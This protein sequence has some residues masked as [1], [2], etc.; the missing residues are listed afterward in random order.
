MPRGTHAP[1]HAGRQRM[2]RRVRRAQAPLN[3]RRR[4]RTMRYGS[5][6]L[7]AAFSLL[8]A[9]VAMRTA[10]NSGDPAASSAPSCSSLPRLAADA[11][12]ATSTPLGVNVSGTSGLTAATAQFGHMPVIRAYYGAVVPNP[13][14]WSTGVL[15]LSHASVV[16]SFRPP[17]AEI[18]SGADDTAL[19]RFF[20]AAP[21]GHAIYY[22]YY[23]EPEAHI[24]AG[25]FTLAQYKA[26]WTHI[27]AIAD[28]AHNPYLH[29]TLILQHQ[30]AD[31]GDQY[32]FRD[33]LPAGGVI[34]TLG[35]DA[36]PVGTDDGHPQPTPP[37]QFM[38]PAVAASKSVGLPFGFAEFALGT[39]TD[40]PQWLTEVANYLDSSGALFGTLFDATGFP[41]TVL[42]DSASI[43]TWRAAV[44]RSASDTPVPAPSASDTPVPAPSAS[45]T[46]VPAPSASDTPV[47]APSASDTP[48]PA[49]SA[50]DTP[51]PAPSA[52]DTP[53]RSTAPSASDTPVPAPS[54]SDTPVPAPSPSTPV[55]VP[56][57]S[58]HP[59][60]SP[61]TRRLVITR[62]SIIPPTLSVTRGNH[63]RIKFQLNH[64]A[65]VSICVLNGQ[66]DVV[67]ELDRPGLSAG[68]AAQRYYGYGR[69]HRLLPPGHY[70]VS[71]MASNATG[72]AAAQLALSLRR[73]GKR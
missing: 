2:P 46:P 41:L 21:T 33:Y 25:Q 63:V 19:A 16:V 61:A 27:V 56:S 54:A 29:S 4:G 3:P 70:Q 23:H 24:K 40:R 60:P 31:P 26:A 13:Q 73:P 17:P 44:A 59:S 7:A 42:H 5:V 1:Q 45:D 72:S 57:R 47:P 15:G 12:I 67:R 37:A 20:D 38:G 22:S 10:A 48:V 53:V 43:Q 8:A 66:G 28:A 62:L 68:W 65:D 49:P 51:V 36:Y 6:A 52:S 18:L 11:S 71:V 9:M 14:Q 58:A 55:P 34:S 32:N 39:L 50:S 64:A 69:H 30:D 35:W